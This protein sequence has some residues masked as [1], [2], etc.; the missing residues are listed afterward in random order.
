MNNQPITA[1]DIKLSTT[2]I[3]KL[4][5]DTINSINCDKA[6]QKRKHIDNLRNKWMNAK[7]IEKEAP[8]NLENAEKNYYVFV[9][10]EHKYKQILLNRYNKQAKQIETNTLKIH[11][12][13]MNEIKT[14]YDYYKSQVDSSQKLKNYLKINKDKNDKLKLELDNMISS[15]QTNDRKSVYEKNNINYVKKFFNI[16]LL[17]FVITSIIFL[18]YSI[19]KYSNTKNVMDITKNVGIIVVL[20]ILLY[21]FY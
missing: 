2:K 1:S 14:Y 15:I 6:C 3:N 11:N 21:Y 9:D 20:Y 12:E 18:I 10:G 17:L 4:I 16:I 5:N 13:L 19:N 8:I 7:K